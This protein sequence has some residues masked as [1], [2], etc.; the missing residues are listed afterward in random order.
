M[1]RA[2]A[3]LVAACFG[4]PLAAAAA[5]TLGLLCIP[6][7][8][9]LGAT[10]DPIDTI[11]VTY[12]GEEWTVVHSATSGKFYV[13][14]EQYDIRDTSSQGESWGWIGVHKRKKGI[15]MISM[16]YRSGDNFVYVENVSDLATGKTIGE[17]TARCIERKSLAES[18]GLLDVQAKVRAPL[19]QQRP[20]RVDTVHGEKPP[21]SRPERALSA[22]FD[23]SGG[24]PQVPVVINE[25]LSL[26]FILD[27]GATD[28]SIPSDVA[29]TL[30]RTGTIADSDFLGSSDYTLAD[31]STSSASRINIRSLSVGGVTVR[32]VTASVANA[33]GPLLLGQ[34]FLT[35]LPK[36]TINNETHV[37]EFEHPVA[38]EIIPK[39]D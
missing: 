34:S 12:Q 28:V 14:S 3:L 5:P 27:S 29:L 21:Q 23:I 16:T 4:W 38:N 15:G 31:G 18:F 9:Q 7:P 13:R 2:A 22:Q 35:R 39:N 17:V 30:V 6:K 36:W 10:P 1:S 8:D 19:A 32:N 20:A 33:A 25:R 11:S 24:V 37:F 26:D